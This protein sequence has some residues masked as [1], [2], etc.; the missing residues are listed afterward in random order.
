M[1]KLIGMN[2]EQVQAEH[3]ALAAHLSSLDAAIGA[4]NNIRLA[5]LSPLN[6]GVPVGGLV[7][8]PA[9]ISSTTTAIAYLHSARNN[10]QSLVSNLAAQIEEQ[11]DA[12]G[13][14]N[15]SYY[16]ASTSSATGQAT[17]GG[18]DAE[19]WW[20]GAS[21]V[22]DHGHDVFDLATEGPQAGWGLWFMATSV[23]GVNSFSELGEAGDWASALAPKGIAAVS[24]FVENSHIGAFGSVLGYVGA[25]VSIIKAGATWMDPTSTAWDKTRDT[26]AAGLAVAGAVALAVGLASN[27]IGW[28]I[29]GAGLAWAAT[30][31]IVDNHKA[32]GKWIGEAS[33]N[34]GNVVNAGAKAV[35]NTGKA[36]VKEVSQV[37]NNV[38]NAGKS[39]VGGI[40]HGLGLAWP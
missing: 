31:Y 9:A 11:R 26:V 30:S 12:S 10:A 6:Y 36:A 14:G 2:P 33:K 39:F 28:A 20:I 8:A 4:V 7:L 18:K 25:G 3:S 21:D 24:D 38:V 15:A 29:L 13:A 27:P 22:F 40:S 17:V 5:S 16:S 37:T 32:I 23:R 35:V 19:P 34:V 1:T